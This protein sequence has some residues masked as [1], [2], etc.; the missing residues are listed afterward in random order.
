MSKPSEESIMKVYE[1][2]CAGGGVTH[3]QLH[4][5][6][7]G[8]CRTYIDASL[9]ELTRRDLIERDDSD[10]PPRYRAKGERR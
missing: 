9:G 7:P 8:I 1:T 3:L 6:L 4:R 10:W 2:I 5:A